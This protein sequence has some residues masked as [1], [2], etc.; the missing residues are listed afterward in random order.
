MATKEKPK[1][2]VSVEK[3]DQ[4]LASIRENFKKGINPFAALL[5]ER[6]KQENGG[7]K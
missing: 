7:N 2:A 3:A 6:A 5:A 4:M 1:N